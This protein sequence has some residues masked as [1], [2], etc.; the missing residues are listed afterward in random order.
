MA[1]VALNSLSVAC[2]SGTDGSSESDSMQTTT[3]I[4]DPDASA[5]GLP[6]CDEAGVRSCLHPGPTIA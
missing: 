3:T 5:G 1:V 6:T 2:T 4:P